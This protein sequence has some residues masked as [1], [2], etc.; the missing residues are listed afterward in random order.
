MPIRQL[1][2]I[3]N[4]DKVVH[5]PVHVWPVFWQILLQRVAIY[6]GMSF[7]KAIHFPTIK[8]YRT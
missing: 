6:L 7:M 4:I 2:Y 1:E 8:Y 3:F 5:V